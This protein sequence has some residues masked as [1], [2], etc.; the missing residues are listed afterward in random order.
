MS[1]KV[2]ITDLQTEQFTFFKKQHNMKKYAFLILASAFVINLSL[3]AQDQSPAGKTD[4][5]QNKE[6]R[7][8]KRQQA[9]PQMRAEGLAKQLSL[10]AAEK[11]K[12]QALY[13]KQDEE[14]KKI[15]A[16]TQM[17]R[18]ELKAL[19]EAERKIQDEELT[20][21]IGTEK[22]QKL[23]TMRAERLKQWNENKKKETEEQ[24]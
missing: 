19:L 21:I 3:S 24:K 9:T 20:K 1:L 23:Q 14:R 5:G 11:A 2:K 10:T 15:Q 22:M 12:V 4:N 16:N 17:T 6:A 7:T 18:E 13:E 8:G